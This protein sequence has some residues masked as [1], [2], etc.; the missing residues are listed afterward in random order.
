MNLEQ[1]LKFGI[2]QGASS[3]HL[4]AESPPQLRING[5]IRGVEGSSVK[6]AE[7]KAFIASIAPKPVADDID[8][9]LGAGAVFSTS[10]PTGRFRCSAFSQIAGP[11]LVL[12]VIP[13]KIPSLEEL[14]LPRSVR[15]VALASRGLI[16]V[17]GP[18]GSGRT[19]TLA[20]M[21]DLINGAAYQ[22]VVTI[23]A[24]VE[25]LH[26]NKKALFT[27]ME[28]GQNASSFEHGLS[29]AL[30]QDADVIVVGELNDAV[31][32]RMVI[33]AVEAGRKVL[34]TITGNSTVGAITQLVSLISKD[35][36]ETA[37]SRVAGA[38]EG[39]VAQQLAKTRDG[40]LRPAVE[41]FRGGLN[42]TRPIMENRI[43]DLN[44]FIESRQGG[45]QSIDQHLLELHQAGFISGT[46]TMRLANN[47]EAVGIGL[48]ALRQASATSSAT[49]SSPATP[50]PV[51]A[52]P[53]LA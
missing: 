23:E 36:R 25:Y 21:V 32:A 41:V 52:D 6:A 48:R 15:D 22:K 53:G 8:R 2:D 13:P 39:V 7:L 16:L 44:F 45:M 51:S 29:L 49:G 37:L 20:A 27:Q 42:T 1:L 35:A 19:T 5:L 46:E 11:G 12:R 47:P 38:L 33:D 31:V 18:S 10:V 3:I 28:V 30:Q 34:L 14:N 9:S 26:T 17:A 4:Q 24:P 40:K 43:K 50:S